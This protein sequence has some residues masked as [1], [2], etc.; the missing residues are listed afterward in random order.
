[1]ARQAGR[2]RGAVREKHSFTRSDP[3]RWVPESKQENTAGS[4]N[5]ARGERS[6]QRAS[7]E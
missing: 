4:R 5:Q 7:C 2:S 6:A 1:M 3:A